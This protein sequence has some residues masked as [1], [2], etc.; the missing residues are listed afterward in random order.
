MS[1][2]QSA[3]GVPCPFNTFGITVIGTEGGPDYVRSAVTET[4]V[5]V[6]ERAT[7]T[8]W[9]ATEPAGAIAKV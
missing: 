7:S 3:T 2:W 1:G 8:A 6:N 4:S 9:V 5:A